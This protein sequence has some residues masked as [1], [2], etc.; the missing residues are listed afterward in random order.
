ML[1]DGWKRS[2][3]VLHQR[4]LP[5]N[6]SDIIDGGKGHG[7]MTS[8]EGNMMMFELLYTILK[9]LSS[10]IRSKVGIVDGGIEFILW[11]LS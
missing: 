4:A 1:V 7:V 9:L 5:I 8:N 6:M 11:K 10:A 2:R 3:A